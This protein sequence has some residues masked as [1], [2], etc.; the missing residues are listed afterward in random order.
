M[1]DVFV[2]TAGWGHLVDSTQAQ[3]VQAATLYRTGRQQGRKFITTNYI[4]TELVALLTSPLRIPRPAIIGFINSLKTSPYVEIVHIDATLDEQAWRL[5]S[6][7]RDKEWSLVDYASFVLMKQRQVLGG[8][9]V[10]GAEFAVAAVA[11]ALKHDIDEVETICEEVAGQGHFLEERGIAEWP[12]G[13]ISRRYGFR[14]ALYQNVLYDRIAETRRVRLHRLVGER[15]ETG[16]ASRAQ[17]IAAELA[18]HFERGR[19]YPRAVQYCQ[20]AER[21]VERIVFEDR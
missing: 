14:H 7:R 16:Y 21:E 12:D 9:S 6:Q 2:D 4:L 5:L 11:A 17:E 8:A 19:N 10:A 1:T 20:F 3:H 18:V 15:L 13:T